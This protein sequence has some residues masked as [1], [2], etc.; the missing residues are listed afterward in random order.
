MLIIGAQNF[1]SNDFD[2]VEKYK[3]LIFIF[4]YLIHLVFSGLFF[5][6]IYS[7]LLSNSM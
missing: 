1:C 3:S 5:K 2:R 7:S 6:A 4:E